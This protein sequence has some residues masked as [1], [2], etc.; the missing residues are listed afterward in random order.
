ME[1]EHTELSFELLSAATERLMKRILAEPRERLDVES[2][3][4][5]F[6]QMTE[7]AANTTPCHASRQIDKRRSV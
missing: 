4:K 2:I 5:G 3:L 1:N 6:D 7:K